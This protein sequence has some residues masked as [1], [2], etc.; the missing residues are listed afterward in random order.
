MPD[1]LCHPCGAPLCPRLAVRRGYC[2]EHAKENSKR[3]YAED[4]RRRGSPSTQGYGR[5]HSRWSRMVL[6]RDI[7]CQHC[8]VRLATQADH[9]IP[10]KAGGS[11]TEFSNG[12]G[13]CRSCHARKTRKENSK[14][15]D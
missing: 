5:R 15:M 2:I 7:V 10:V 6:A 3:V 11:W 8:R 14:S 4:H 13:L 9:V 1:K 12:A